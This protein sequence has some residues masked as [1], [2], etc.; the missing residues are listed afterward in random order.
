MALNKPFA[1]YLLVQNMFIY[2]KNKPIKLSAIR[3]CIEADE[4]KQLLELINNNYNAKIY[5][6]ICCFTFLP[7]IKCIEYLISEGT[8]LNE[9]FI[10]NPFN[11]T[12]QEYLN[13][14]LNHLSLSSRKK[15]EML[16]NEAIK[17]GLSNIRT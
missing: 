17:R 11:S 15:V 1:N 9:T 7:A 16:I 13:N 14:F 5:C 10:D 8:P 12:P 4:P 2:Y 3:S 6:L